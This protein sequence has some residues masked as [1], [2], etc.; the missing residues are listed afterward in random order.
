MAPNFSAKILKNI[1]KSKY[2][3]K[4]NKNKAHTHA[5]N[6]ILMKIRR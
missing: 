5:I 6:F 3:A 2:N 1:A 4:K